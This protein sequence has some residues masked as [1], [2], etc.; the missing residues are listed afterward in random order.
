MHSE[1]P[2]VNVKDAG[3]NVKNAGGILFFIIDFPNSQSTGYSSQNGSLCE[4]I[5]SK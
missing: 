4:R 3:K 1:E 5:S 2:Y